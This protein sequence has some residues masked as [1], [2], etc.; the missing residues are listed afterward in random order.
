[1]SFWNIV[2]NFILLWHNSRSALIFIEST[3]QSVREHG[4]TKGLYRGAELSF[5]HFD[6]NT[7]KTRKGTD[8]LRNFAQPMRA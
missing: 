1:M 2:T 7:V 4:S 5:I 8:I 6:M 3:D